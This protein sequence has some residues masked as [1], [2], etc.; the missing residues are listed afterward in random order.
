MKALIPLPSCET[1]GK[2]CK[3]RWRVKGVPTRFCSNP[4]V[5]RELRAAG[6]RR[7]RLKAA[8]RRRVQRFQGHLKRLQGLERVTGED[9]MAT[10]AAIAREEYKRGYWSCEAKW[11][12]T[13]SRRDVA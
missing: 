1:C 4:C 5:P 11:Q 3:D 10:F 13:R 6:G 2:P 7:G 8:A 12:W 9:L